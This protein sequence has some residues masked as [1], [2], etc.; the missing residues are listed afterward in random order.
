MIDHVK[1]VVAIKEARRILIELHHEHSEHRTRLEH[2]IDQL[3]EA[4]SHL[5][6]QR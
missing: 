4:L 1:L 2:T 6:R 5:E 3:S